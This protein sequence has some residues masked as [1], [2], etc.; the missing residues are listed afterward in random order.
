MNRV[1]ENLILY[2]FAFEWIFVSSI[3]MIRRLYKFAKLYFMFPVGS[4]SFNTAYEND[5]AHYKVHKIPI[6]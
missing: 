1:F 4:S 6:Q 5:L 3:V 2:R